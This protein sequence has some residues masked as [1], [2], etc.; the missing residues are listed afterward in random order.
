MDQELMAFA[1]KYCKIKG[2]NNNLHPD[3]YA[4]FDDDFTRQNFIDVWRGLKSKYADE[5]KNKKLYSTPDKKSIPYEEFLN[6]YGE[7]VTDKCEEFEGEYPSEL[8]RVL[9]KISNNNISKPV[10]YDSL[11]KLLLAPT[12]KQEPSVIIQQQGYTDKD[13][14]KAKKIG[15]AS[16]KR[17]ETLRK[18]KEAEEAE[19]E[20]LIES[21]RIKDPDMSEAISSIMADAIDDIEPIAAYNNRQKEGDTTKIPNDLITG[22]MFIMKP[23]EYFLITYLMRKRPYVAETKKGNKIVL[24]E[25]AAELYRKGKIAVLI[26]KTSL[27]KQLNLSRPTIIKA[28]KDMEKACLIV[29]EKHDGDTFIIIGE[30]KGDKES[31]FYKKQL[32]YKNVLL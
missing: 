11:E 17:A 18:K 32:E 29:E 23:T 4:T 22:A 12:K 7:V 16:Q 5:I 2:I 30:L 10:N 13:I 21:M 15:A 19:R 9:F 3:K 1:Y 31:Y 28:L 27:A 14:E 20:A 25:E 8:H 6:K 24:P 26:N